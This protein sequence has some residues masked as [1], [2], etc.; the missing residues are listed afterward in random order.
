MPCVDEPLWHGGQPWR[1]RALVESG[2]GSRGLIGGEI[3]PPEG[4]VDLGP[5]QPRPG[6]Q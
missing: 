3:L 5:L 1:R 4:G 6:R 2:A